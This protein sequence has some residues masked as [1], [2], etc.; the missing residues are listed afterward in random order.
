MSP[1][2]SVP[3]CLT[4][5]DKDKIVLIG[6]TDIHLANKSPGS[7]IYPT[8][9]REFMF[10]CMDQIYKFAK[11]E[12]ADALVVAGDVFHTRRPDQNPPAFINECIRVFK[13]FWNNDIPVFGIAGNHDLGPEG[14]SS[15]SDQ[16]LGTLEL[17][18]V[19]ELLD[20]YPVQISSLTGGLSCFI[21][22][23]SW[24][25]GIDKFIETA[26]EKDRTSIASYHIRL[27]HFL[28]GPKSGDLFGERVVG[29]DA[30]CHGD[31]DV[32]FTGHR[33][34]DQ[35]IT[36]TG[37]KWYV[38]P[39][40]VTRHGRYAH[41]KFRRPACVRMVF[42]R[43]TGLSIRIARLKVPPSEELFDFET[44]DEAKEDHK[45]LASFVES[46][47]NHVITV[48]DDP[49]SII[50]GLNINDEVI[51]RAVGYLEK[52]EEA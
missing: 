9:Y 2:Y 44:L 33:H 47:Q 11:H 25:E 13:Q 6:C 24:G 43:D 12:N 5:K 36:Y 21:S 7:W 26:A 48:N 1:N 14:F 23:F 30:L 34:D 32:V 46:M 51:T 35:G 20:N 4:A 52:A 8:P 49:K 10:Q 16:P 42:S 15:L 18:G 31:Y 37:D 41:D 27:G 40:A 19:Y 50:G 29:P 39:G 17:A 38:N 28:F 3:D 22:G 45:E